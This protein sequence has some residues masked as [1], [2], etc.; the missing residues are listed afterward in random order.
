M[1]VAKGLGGGYIPLG[2]TIYHDRVAAPIFD[3]YGDVITG[4]TF[5]GHTAACA[6]GVAVQKIVQRD[7]LLDHVQ[8]QGMW[9]QEQLH[10]ELDDHPHI[11]NIRGRGFF[12]GIE[13]VEDRAT[14]TPFDPAQQIFAQIKTQAFENGLI[15]YPVGGNVDGERG[16]FAIL[17]PPY[18]AT[19]AELSEIIEK[20]VLT[21]KEVLP[22]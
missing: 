4:H 18:N 7:R 22:N 9:M 10:A 3:V 13:F 5:T 21:C 1:S 17:S 16:D 19:K 12:I 15:C 2:A 11:G 20:F 8:T 6:A 14:K